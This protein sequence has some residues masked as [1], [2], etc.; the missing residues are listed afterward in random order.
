MLVVMALGGDTPIRLVDARRAIATI[1][2]EH[3]VVVTHSNGPHPRLLAKQTESDRAVSPIAPGAYA[4]IVKWGLEKEMPGRNVAS[5]VTDVDVG[6][7]PVGPR[8]V[9]TPDG[10]RFV[11]ELGWMVIHDGTG[12]R[13]CIPTP[14]PQRIHQLE[15][16]K[17]QIEAGAL[18]ICTFGAGIAITESKLWL[19]EGEVQIDEDLAAALL[20]EQIGA[21]LLMLLGNVDVERVQVDWPR[22]AA[23]PLGAS[24]DHALSRLSFGPGLI[25][26]K[27]EAACR[28]VESTG[29]R[30][31]IGG[32]AQAPEILRGDRGVQVT[33]KSSGTAEVGGVR[34]VTVLVADDND[35]AL[36][37]CRRVLQKAGYKVL[38]ATHGLEAVSLALA[39]SPDVILMDVAMPGIDGL[40][41]TRRIK[42]QRPG[43]AIVIASVLATASNRERFLASGAD[44]VMMK[45]FRLS[46]MIAA[47]ARFTANREPQ[48][49]DVTGPRLG[50]GEDGEDVLELWNAYEIAER[51]GAGGTADVRTQK[52]PSPESGAKKLL[53][54]QTLGLAAQ[55]LDARDRHTESHSIRV[56]ELAGRLGDHLGLSDREVDLLRTAG[57]MHDLGMIGVRDDVLG[58]EGRLT[59]AEWEAIRRHPDIGADMLTQHSLLA[60]VAPIVR[61]HH[62]HWDGS[63]YPAGLKGTDIPLG[64]R[65]IAVAEAFD[66][67]TIGRVYRKSVMTPIEAVEDIS[68]HA[69]HWFDPNVVDALREIHGLS[70]L[71]VERPL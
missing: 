15:T 32:L 7:V 55:A 26:P 14:R 13:R 69:N 51:L 70:P 37:L 20:A 56:S 38:T 57:S 40:E 68:R 24:T 53:K 22:G 41:A 49:K 71:E 63:G 10:R 29:K 8:Y 35:V 60:E 39:R 31:V 52:D 3:T 42:Q 9:D 16:I 11:A 21:D 64:A 28:F 36:R 17:T 27:A 30:A 50:S 34:T 43:I 46:D 61:H 5:L 4:R 18:L 25:G 6:L 66:A 23:P 33:A 44:H 62:E 47:V 59:E 45:P 67:I 54:D 58:K 48:M 12:F 19:R 2:G 1:A 65:I